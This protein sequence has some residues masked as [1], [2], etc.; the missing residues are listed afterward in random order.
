MGRKR[1]RKWYAEVNKRRGELIGKKNRGGL[2]ESEET[3]LAALQVR[4][5]AEVNRVLP[6]PEPSPALQRLLEKYG[7]ND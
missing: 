5:L 7:E 1:L 6:R 2:T 3:E 4:C